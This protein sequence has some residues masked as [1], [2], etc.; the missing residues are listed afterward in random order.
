MGLR[1]WWNRRDGA[2]VAMPLDEF[3]STSLIGISRGIRKAN[4]DLK[5]SGERS[6]SNFFLEPTERTQAGADPLI[7]FDVAVTSKA[8]GAGKVGVVGAVAASGSVAV[9]KETVSRIQFVVYVK[10]WLA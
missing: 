3:I 6:E 5:V 1:A 4:Q 8:E 10:N 9:A 2:H 7:R